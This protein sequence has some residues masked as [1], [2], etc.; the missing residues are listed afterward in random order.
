MPNGTSTPT[1]NPSTLLQQVFD[2]LDIEP[3][4]YL[5]RFSK[6]NSK[7]G[8]VTGF[9]KEAGKIADP[10]TQWG[11]NGG[12][13]WVCYNPVAKVTDGRGKAEDVVVMSGLHADLDVKS[14]S[15]ADIESAR[16]F[17]DMVSEVLGSQPAVII[18][19]G[20]GLQPIWALENASYLSNT[21]KQAL[22]KWFGN[23]L[24]G[25]GER[26]GV[27]LDSVFDLSRVL[28][29]PGTLNWKDPENPKQTG[30]ELPDNYRPLSVDEVEDALN[31]RGVP[32]SQQKSKSD[33]VVSSVDGWPEGKTCSYVELM[34]KSWATDVPTAGRHQ[35]AA[36]QATRLI[37]AWRVGCISQV[38]LNKAG[39]VLQRRL[40]EMRDTGIAGEK[41]ETDPKEVRDLARWAAGEV[42]TKSDEET[43]DELGSHSH[44][45]DDAE[46]HRENIDDL[47]EAI[48][49]EKST[50][51]VSQK[52]GYGL[53]PVE[54][55]P[56]PSSSDMKFWDKHPVLRQIYDNS[57]QASISP[58][59]GLVGTLTYLAADLPVGMKTATGSSLSLFTAIYG[60]SGTGKSSLLTMLDR[61]GP[62]APTLNGNYWEAAGGVPGSGEG[63]GRYYRRWDATTS[64]YIEQN[65]KAL[66]RVDEAATFIAALSR[67]SNT[68]E[69]VLNSGFM[70]D[71]LALTYG[72]TGNSINVP[73][74]T[75]TMGVIMGIQPGLMGGVLERQHSGFFQRFLFTETVDELYDDPEFVMKSVNAKNM[76]VGY[77]RL[78]FS[79]PSQPFTVQMPA[80]IY[81]GIEFERRI[82]ASKK[83]SRGLELDGGDRSHDTMIRSR[84]ASLLAI[85]LGKREFGDWEFEVAGGIMRNSLEVLA[86]SRGQQTLVD[87]KALKAVGER[88]ARV[89]N[90][91]EEK[92]V[93]I[94]ADKIAAKLQRTVV[95]GAEFD[96][97]ELKNN[98]AK[99][100]RPYWSG[101]M[102]LLL[103][104]GV[105]RYE[106]GE[107][108]EYGKRHYFYEGESK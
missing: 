12:D 8:T 79:I 63:I 90:V 80:H 89:E 16:V 33:L 46:A 103:E 37:A 6:S 50:R 3:T 95:V 101:A 69:G 53:V 49:E 92:R 38:D 83:R 96:R 57:I 4:D 43:R 10:E 62:R 67:Q 105:I 51:I 41:G 39:P 30:L 34:V 99:S 94:L 82:K 2:R 15:F 85:L 107:F 5:S 108:G 100:S 35:W 72:G 36:S 58:L 70:G 44:A 55:C 7:T 52:R 97:R 26:I 48:E 18:R 23:F 56:I 68:A 93:S 87:Q 9:T 45:G 78:S 40:K 91:T 64:Q 31:L 84:V 66:F 29:I 1:T 11:I 25:E 14:G 27:S 17:I 71:P 88:V 60:Y 59:A 104:R 19:S 98:R 75:Y 61:S 20:N 22:L 86:N 74:E 42:Q 24:Q 81:K 21:G 76:G 65:E 28:R 47:I 32:R 77:Q 73:A 54:E 102:D 13:M 106:N